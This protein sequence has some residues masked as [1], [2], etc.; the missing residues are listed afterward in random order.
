LRWLHWADFL[1]RLG[2][3]VP[4]GSESAEPNETEGRSDWGHVTEYEILLLLDPDLDEGRQSEIVS[5]TREL[6]EKAGGSWDL[7]DPWGRRRL[8]YEIRHKGEGTY[9]LLHFS[10]E[11]ETLD[12]V[13]RVLRI[14]D[15]VM[16]HMATRR[17]K[18]SP[19]RPVAVAAPT[20]NDG[21]AAPETEEEP[22]EEEE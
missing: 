22:A 12:E 7:H 10:C 1:L 16:R 2:P 5:R 21:G 4:G 15:G 8:A 17:L 9:H 14:D 3:S 13:S 18:G 20:R 6:V 11:P 19:S